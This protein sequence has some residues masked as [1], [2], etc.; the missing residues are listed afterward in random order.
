M[1]HWASLIVFLAVVALAAFFGANFEPGDWYQSLTKPDWTPPNWLF[2]PVWTVLYVLIAVAGWLVWRASGLSSALVVWGI[3][4]VLNGLWSF[5]M[6]GQNQIGLA[7]V[8][9]SALWLAIATFIV[10]A[11]PVS[12]LAAFLFVPYLLWVSYASALNCAL[13][14]LNG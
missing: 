7:L 10:L 11:W 9:I 12:R 3:G 2:G 6:F 1:A 8:D 5:L 4:L 13:W 14:Q